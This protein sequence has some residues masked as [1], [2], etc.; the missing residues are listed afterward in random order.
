[1]THTFSEHTNSLEEG[2]QFTR[3]LV[4]HKW[5]SLVA[6]KVWFQIQS[7]TEDVKVY[8]IRYGVGVTIGAV[9]IAEGQTVVTL[10][11]NFDIIENVKS[12]VASLLLNR[13]ETAENVNKTIHEIFPV[14]GELTTGTG[15]FVYKWELCVFRID[16]EKVGDSKITIYAVQ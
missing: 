7:N 16:F 14:I 6:E 13:V 9:T 5:S 8:I 10:L 11:K 15:V 2:F 4:Q 3:G 1:M 12:K